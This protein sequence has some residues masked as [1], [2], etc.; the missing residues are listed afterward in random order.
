MLAEFHAVVPHPLTGL[1]QLR[2][3][4]HKEECGE[5]SE[6]LDELAGAKSQR[7]AREARLHV[8]R[9][10]ADVVYVCY[11]TAHSLGIDLDIALREVHR[12]NMTKTNGKRRADGKLMKP[13]GFVAP[14]MTEAV[15]PRF[16]GPMTDEM[17]AAYARD[18]E[19]KSRCDSVARDLEWI[20][21]ASFGVMTKPRR[22]D[23]QRIIQTLRDKSAHIVRV[24]D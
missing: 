8:A 12:A 7:V 20:L 16:A 3:D 23:F 11:G 2:D 17:S 24:W 21:E 19:M 18:Y 10:L 1:L 4:L 14:D 13:L 5:L 22:D 9:E 15:G 6:A